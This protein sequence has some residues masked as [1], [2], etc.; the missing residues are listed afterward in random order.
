MI[1]NLRPTR[2]LAGW[3]QPLVL[4]LVVAVPLMASAAEDWAA[5]RKYM[6]DELVVKP[7]VKNPRVIAAMRAVPRHEFIPKENRTEDAYFDIAIPIGEQQTI[8]PPFVVASMTERLD[9]QPTDKVLE[10][11]TGSGYQ[12]AV[13]S[14]VAGETY[15]IEIKEKLGK[16]AADTLNRLGFKVH[17]K[18][19][20]GYKGWPEHAPF[21]KIIVTCSP[22]H[23]P[24]PLIDQLRD[25]GRMIVPVGQR[26]QQILYLFHKQNGKLER[27]ALEATMFVPMTGT[28]ESLRRVQ[29]DAEHPSLVNGG[30]EASTQIEGVPD[31]WYY[32][33][34]G[35]L[36][37]DASAPE[38]HQ[39]LQISNSESEKFAQALQAFGVDGRKVRKLDVSVWVRGRDIRPPRGR[40][41]VAA[42]LMLNYYDKDRAPIRQEALGPWTGTFDWSEKS[43]VVPVPRNARMV[44]LYVGLLGATG[45][46]SFDDVRIVPHTPEK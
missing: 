42:H 33:R 10:I 43:G 3:R 16:R 6:V 23:I 39:Y 29:Y 40:P 19:G 15:S 14:L 41:G 21:D 37:R 35:R 12:A 45:E 44:V 31:G 27:E 17:T 9:P 5:A 28:A 20:D 32:V 26:F 46:A 36:V 13:M 8:S 7:G 25:G 24:Q 4:W 18:I 38:G 30:L 34:Q 22:E 2:G 1:A 11:G